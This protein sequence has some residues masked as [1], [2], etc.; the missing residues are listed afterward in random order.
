MLQAALFELEGVLVDTHAARREALGRALADD[1]V[2]LAPDRFDA[3]CAG[4]PVDRAVDEALRRL[5]PE[6]PA[7]AALDDTA[8]ELVARRAERAVS[9][10]LAAGVSLAPG[11][12]AALDALGGALRLGLVTRAR[13]RDVDGVLALAGLDGHFAC[14]VTADDVRDAKPA[15][16]GYRAALARLARRGVDS[17]AAVVAFEDAAP[18]V[19]AAR[20]AGVRIVRVSPAD[21]VDADAAVRRAEARLADV[22]TA[23]A[24]LSSLSGLTPRSLA[25]LLDLAPA[26]T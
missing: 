24:R 10:R 2:F 12:R 9:D 22:R 1:G 25:A 18:G 17:P 21:A 26:L 16:D 23:D 8:R 5:A 4:L 6:N 3:W 7:A 15:P 19:A 11:A 13:R 20:A 14:V